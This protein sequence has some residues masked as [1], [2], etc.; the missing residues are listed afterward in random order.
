MTYT[1]VVLGKP[2]VQARPRIGRYGG[3]YDP[4]AKE[5]K[6]LSQELLFQRVAQGKALFKGEVTVIAHF[7]DAPHKRG[8][9]PDIDNFLKAL[10][11]AGNGVLWQDDSQIVECFCS[12]HRNCEQPR[13]QLTLSGE[14]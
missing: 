8:Q 1:I 9:K 10:F 4:I 11:D 3:M 2:L 13:T 14:D 12:I 5:K 6:A 7:W